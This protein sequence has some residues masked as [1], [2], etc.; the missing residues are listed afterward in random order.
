M[1][2]LT[3][4]QKEVAAREQLILDTARQMFNE[5]GYLGLSMDKIAQAIEYSKGTV[6]Q[7]FSSKEDLIGALAIESVKIR[8]RLFEMAGSF[9]G[10]P[11][12]RIIAVG[13]ADRVLAEHHPDTA[14]T[15]QLLDLSLIMEK[16]SEQRRHTLVSVKEKMM[17]KL[18]AIVQ[19][20]IDVGDIVLPEGYPILSVLYGMWSMSIGHVAMRCCTEGVPQ[21][22]TIDPGRALWDNYQYLLDGYDWKPLSTEW[23]YHK[24]RKRVY[25]EVFA[26]HYPLPDDLK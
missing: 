21:L 1:I 7:H 8:S 2:Q 25:E 15:E 11:R 19:D 18:I 4:K 26:K 20:G 12:E 6:Y 10:R 16:T 23:D 13:I 24:T 14:S 5:S 22:D 17:D 9:Q 3:R